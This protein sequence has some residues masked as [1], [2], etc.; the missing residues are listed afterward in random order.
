MDFFIYRVAV[1]IHRSVAPKL[2]TLYAV[3]LH[4]PQFCTEYRVTMRPKPFDC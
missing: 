1:Q 3:A 4:D 2:Q